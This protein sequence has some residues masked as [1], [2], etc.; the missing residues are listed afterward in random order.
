MQEAME[1][2]QILEPERPQQGWKIV[3]SVQFKKSVRKILTKYEEKKKRG[4]GEGELLL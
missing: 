4:N 3:S 1:G 2:S